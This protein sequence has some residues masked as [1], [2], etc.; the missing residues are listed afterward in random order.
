MGLDPSSKQRPAE[1][2]PCP[3]AREIHIIADHGVG[4][5]E[6]WIIG[7]EVNFAIGFCASLTMACV[8]PARPSKEIFARYSRDDSA[9]S[10]RAAVSRQSR[11]RPEATTMTEPITRL[12][13]GT[14]PQIANPRM[15]AQTSE[16]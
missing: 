1:P 10:C 9:T 8:V 6:A 4:K 7:G 3:R 5:K 13:V 14:S 11:N 16:K 2:V 15:L 12:R